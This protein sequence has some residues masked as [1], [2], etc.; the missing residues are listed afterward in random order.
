MES[1][2]ENQVNNVNMINWSEEWKTL[3][4]LE[5]EVINNYCTMCMFSKHISD[6]IF[7]IILKLLDQI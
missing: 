5:K 1:W 2:N 6:G 3:K 7:H 4:W